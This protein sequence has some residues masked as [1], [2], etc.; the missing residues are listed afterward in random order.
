VERV[1]LAGARAPRRARDRAGARDG[2]LHRLFDRR[3]AAGGPRYRIAQHARFDAHL[4]YVS[5][6]GLGAVVELA[7]SGS[8]TWAQEPRL[9]P[10]ASVLRRDDAFAERY[11][12]LDP[13]EYQ[14]LV[15]QSKRGLFDRDTVPGPEPERLLELDVPALVVPGRDASHAA[16]AARYLEECLGAEYWDVLPEEQ[17]AANAPSRVLEFLTK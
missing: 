13:Q 1:R 14:A 15:E 3:D 17:T 2:R 9:G 6:A 12:A 5:E 10:W 16:S 11:A 7:R 8:E 4:A